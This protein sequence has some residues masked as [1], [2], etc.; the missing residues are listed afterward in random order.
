MFSVVFVCMSKGSP[1]REI[2]SP[3]HTATQAPLDMFYLV[4]YVA[5]ASVRKRVVAIRLKCILI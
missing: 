5:R 4:R 3:Y 2:P 1:H